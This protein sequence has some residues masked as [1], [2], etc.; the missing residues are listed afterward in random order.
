MVRSSLYALYAAVSVAAICISTEAQAQARATSTASQQITSSVSIV[1]G[2]S[3]GIR[4][5][6]QGES[7]LWIEANDLKATVMTRTEGKLFR[8]HAKPSE[9]V[10]AT[11]PTREIAVAFE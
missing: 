3:L 2:I 5:S 1:D 10:V 9:N 6:H 8:V 11:E 4:K 7:E